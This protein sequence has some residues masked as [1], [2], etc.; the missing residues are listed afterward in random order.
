MLKAAYHLFV[1][2]PWELRMWG[3]HHPIAAGAIT[4]LV[5]AG[6][7]AIIRLYNHLEK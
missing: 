5:V 3:I 1:S 4:V 6:G 7:V 2:A